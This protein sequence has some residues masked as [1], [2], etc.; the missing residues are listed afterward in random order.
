MTAKY[1]L[2][3]QDNPQPCPD[4]MEWAAWMGTAKNR[5][6]R[7]DTLAEDVQVSTVFLGID[8]QFGNGDP[9]LYETMIFGGPHD[10]YCD[11]YSRRE[12]AEA[13]HQRAVAIAQ[14]VGAA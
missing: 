13:G 4:V 12:E 1:I 10:G 5:V 3:D 8:H 11:R 9:L 7:Q 6:V 2:D 14:G